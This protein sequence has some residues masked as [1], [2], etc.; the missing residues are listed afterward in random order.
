MYSAVMRVVLGFELTYYLGCALKC[1]DWAERSTRL[2]W[3][4]YDRVAL[5][6]VSKVSA[7]GT[8]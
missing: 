3:E 4:G 6:A 1:Y 5:L 2:E 8:R 7:L